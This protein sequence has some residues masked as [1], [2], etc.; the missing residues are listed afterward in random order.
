[1]L[2]HQPACLRSGR[3]RNKS[4]C[5][6]SVWQG[7]K[8]QPSGGSNSCQCSE[9]LLSLTGHQ[10]RERGLGTLSR[11]S[12]FSALPVNDRLTG[13]LAALLQFEDQTL[14]SVER[15]G[16]TIGLGLCQKNPMRYGKSKNGYFY[17]IY[18]KNA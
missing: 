15:I 10:D 18:W 1:M 13:A 5:R 12:T 7:E 17:K 4:W 8:E 14:E 11:F 2:T 9:E 6:L 16:D 3:M